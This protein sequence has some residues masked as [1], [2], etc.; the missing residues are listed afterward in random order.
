M[1]GANLE[2]RQ[3]NI[4]TARMVFDFL[5]RCVPSFGPIYIEAE[6]FEERY[7]NYD[8]ALLL[9]EKGLN[10]I[11]RYGRCGLPP[12]GCMSGNHLLL[13]AAV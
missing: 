11:P 5:I 12:S 10:D 8:K 9:I 6:K 1:E 7:E 2:A 4:E 13:H 3:G